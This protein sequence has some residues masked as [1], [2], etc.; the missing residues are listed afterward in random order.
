MDLVAGRLYMR[1][2]AQ[3]KYALTGVRLARRAGGKKLLLLDFNTEPHKGNMEQEE[4]A[5]SCSILV[6][7]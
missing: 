6:R 4:K 2:A 3:R 5:S 1:R 7:I